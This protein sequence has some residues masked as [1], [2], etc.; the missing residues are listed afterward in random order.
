[1]NLS[2]VRTTAF[3]L[4]A[5]VLFSVSAAHGQDVEQ[6]KTRAEKAE[7][8]LGPDH[9]DLSTRLYELAEYYRLQ[10]QYTAA[11]PLYKRSL[12]IREKTLGPDHLDVGFSLEKL[13]QIY[14]EQG[15]YAQ[16][17]ALYGRSL[18]IFEK[19]LGPGHHLVLNN[20][21]LRHR[22]RGQYIQAEQLFRRSLALREKEL[23]AD[24]LDVAS[25]LSDLAETCRLQGSYAEAGPLFKRSIDI[26]EKVLGPDNSGTASS[27]NGLGDTYRGQGRYS[28]AQPLLERGLAIRE[29]GFG[30]D[31]PFVSP[32][33]TTLGRLN[34]NQGRY[35]QAELLF[36]RS[37]AIQEKAFGPD[38]PYLASSLNDLAWLYHNQG[39]HAQAE[40]LFRRGL[41]IHQ[42]ARGADNPD[43]AN[44]LN[45]LAETYRR[46]GRYAEAEPFQKRS[47]EILEKALG[48]DHPQVAQSLNNL[49][50]IYSAQNR[51]KLAEPLQKR[52][53]T[54]REKVFGTD[55]FKVAESL[56][57][58]GESYRR[59][60]RYAEAQPLFE[61]SLAIFDKTLGQDHPELAF[62]LTTLAWL[63]QSQGRYGQ[64][65]SLHKRSLAIREKVLGPDHPFV[66]NTLNELA[67]LYFTQGQF[68][69]ARSM[70]RR[71]LA[72]WH[73]RFGPSDSQAT[74]Q[75][76]EQRTRRGQMAWHI[77]LLDKFS[78]AERV[79]ESFET[80]QLAQASTVGQ[81][82]AQMA[83][84]FAAKGDE[85]AKVVR[86]RQDAADLLERADSA[87]SEAVRQPSG[88]DHRTR[89]ATL[90]RQTE[91]LEKS[92]DAQTKLIS[93][94]FPEYD[95]LVSPKP[96]PLAETQKLLEV[97]EAMLMYLVEGQ[98]SFVWALRRDK[99]DFKRL[100]ITAK[101]LEQAVNQLRR[102][103]DPLQNPGALP[104]DAAAAHELY[105]KV[106]A[107]V[108][109]TLVGAKHLIY[110]ADGA[111]QS[112]PMHVLVTKP[113]SD[114]ALPAWMADQYAVSVVP[115]VSALRAL[116]VFS[117]G[118]LAAE[119][120]VG[121]GDPV[122]KGGQAGQRM[123]AMRALF[124]RGS[125]GAGITGIADVDAIRQASPLPETADELRAIAKTLGAPL[126]SLYL[127]RNAT[128]TRA[129]GMD[130]SRYRVIA[131]ATHG[132][133][134]GEIQGIAEP[135]LILTPPEK[136]SVQD[137]GYLSA[138]EVAQL[139]LNADWVILSACNTAAPDGAA[140]IEGLSG[141]AKGFFYAGARSLLVS[142]WS[143]VSEATVQLT[144]E[145]LTY[146]AANPKQGKAQALK[147][148]MRKMKSDLKYSHPLFWAPFMVVGEGGAAK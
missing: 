19:V 142:N 44:G 69:N 13:A 4:L 100:S 15:R 101:E 66:A 76:A 56:N 146:Y 118:R 119:P 73:R 7:R 78:D 70:S 97:D 16:S 28:E 8:E 85:L 46:Q 136:G 65:E 89:I 21:A 32:S 74:E 14:Y 2:R 143:V 29:K 51:A 63:N 18:G 5:A 98:N 68:L 6:L 139:K 38:H 67:W 47:L 79:G 137:D 59:Q 105:K 121:F 39:R 1:M 45:G 148:S 109:S 55:H 27:L 113:V 112:L 103:L 125:E 88:E 54:I 34:Q 116:R 75:L 133:M 53:L 90:R 115:S 9:P 36:K 50:N 22:A 86:D 110:I 11:E 129:K 23:G 48:P 96:I 52:S 108:E 106:L 107:P 71:S 135:G 114:N 91:E 25:S 72:I 82:V 35:A 83:A 140:G 92:L 81:S 117:K 20:L 111:L 37:L 77:G 60:G 42:Q 12:T 93:M 132:V 126:T 64:A 58:L 124:A 94:K 120:F 141:L 127:D 130:L 33:L 31:H 144:T 104:F 24:H 80:A 122:L 62:T 49:G 41:T 26:R 123:I 138:S 61:R 84:R 99:A 147:Q 40:P 30:P 128:E 95:A 145:M 17:G 87:L 131:F 102:R 3:V 134:A 43:V 10:G 57:N